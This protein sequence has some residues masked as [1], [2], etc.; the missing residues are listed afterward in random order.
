MKQDS[1]I[2]K[3]YSIFFALL[4]LGLMVAQSTR[5]EI[6]WIDNKI[7]DVNFQFVE[8]PLMLALLEISL[9]AYLLGAPT[10]KIASRIAEMLG[11]KNQDHS[12]PEE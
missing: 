8:I 11:Y 12:E 4:I 5:V 3:G 1:K 9:I 2:G 10:D 7:V 6:N